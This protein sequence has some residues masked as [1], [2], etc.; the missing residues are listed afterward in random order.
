MLCWEVIDQRS[1][2][3]KSI[4]LPPDSLKGG[5]FTGCHWGLKMECSCF[6]L[7]NIGDCKAA[8][9]QPQP[10]PRLPPH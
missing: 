2:E 8:W 7:L 3:S 10:R 9:E 6:M 4:A 1:G 5:E